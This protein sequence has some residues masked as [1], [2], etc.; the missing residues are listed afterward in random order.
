[1]NFR[2]TGGRMTRGRLIAAQRKE[3]YESRRRMDEWLD[4]RRG[5]DL[6]PDRRPGGGPAGRRDCKADQEIIVRL[7][8]GPFSSAE[9]R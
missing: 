5:M 4:G 7:R 6:G 3:R 9:A 1:M 8:I 2:F